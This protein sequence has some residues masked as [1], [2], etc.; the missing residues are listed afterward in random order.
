MFLIDSNIII[1]SHSNQYEYLRSLFFKESVFVSEISRVEVLGY[2][3]LT[4][5]EENYFQDIFNFIPIISPSPQI[6]DT[7]ITIR[8]TYNLKLGDSIIA[9]TALVHGLSI[10]TRN[11]GDFEKIISLKCTDPAT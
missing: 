6:F 1:Y 11:T 8:K 5:E 9:A 10:Y 7:S 2:H 4:I 3:K